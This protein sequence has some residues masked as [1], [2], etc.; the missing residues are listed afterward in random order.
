MRT[1]LRAILMVALLTLSILVPTAAAH[2]AAGTVSGVVK[3]GTTPVSGVSVA[4]FEPSTG[5]R[6]ATTTNSRGRYSLP[7]SDS[8]TPYVIAVNYN[9]TLSGPAKSTYTGRVVGAGGTAGYVWQLVT[10]FTSTSSRTLN[11]ALRLPGKVAGVQRLLARKP[12]ELVN[13][14][15]E[16]V[17][18]TTASSTGAYSFRGL[19]PGRYRI[20][21]ADIPSY[22]NY[23]SGVLSVVSGKTTT[24]TPR[25][26]RTGT[27]AG[28]VTVDGTP[29]S[30]VTVAAFGTRD[31]GI[32]TTDGAGRFS[33]PQ[34]TAGSYE[35]QLYDSAA[36]SDLDRRFPQVVLTTT[37]ASGAT[38][39]LSPALSSGATLAG[40]LTVAEGTA[41]DVSAVSAD[42]ERYVQGTF[43]GGTYSFPALAGGDY[44][45]TAIDPAG[46]V[47]VSDPVTV[48][49]T[50]STTGPA[51]APSIP[52]KDVTLTVE[53]PDEVTYVVDVVA[54]SL[55]GR[56]VSSGAQG[57]FTFTMSS[58]LAVENTVTIS[59]E[60]YPDQSE[61]IDLATGDT[62][63]VT[64]STTPYPTISGRMT[65]RGTPIRD[66]YFYGADSSDVA[67]YPSSS[68]GTFV[69]GAAPGS[70]PLVEIDW[71]DSSGPLRFPVRSPYYYA[72]PASPLVVGDADASIG[73]VEIRVL[74]G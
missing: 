34:L 36:S 22:G 39:T 31:D 11:V 45:I 18:T 43:A 2:A 52:T 35:V 21:T 4:W 61:T 29:V 63:T 51:L 15:G 59:A 66:M 9:A 68:D 49:P 7:L 10:P 41:V 8:G 1:R 30:G 58:L 5:L 32:A 70:Y 40:E 67:I 28:V 42:G 53:A 47:A 6:G 72:P 56:G 60:G 46:L 50:G 71:F 54:S 17:A 62:F 44:T 57:T 27:L 23:L 13:L 12:V 3:Y 24:H 25:L 26:A 74:G 14:A 64:L 20:Q 69:W 48:A 55:G 73:D 38:R 65:V 33:I 16:V 19:I 37:V